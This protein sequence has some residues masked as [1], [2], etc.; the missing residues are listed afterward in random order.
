MSCE[1]CG[2]SLEDKRAIAKYCS[3]A[4]RAKGRRQKVTQTS[5]RPDHGHDWTWERTGD[6]YRWRCGHCGD[7]VEARAPT[8][9]FVTDCTSAKEAV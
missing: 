9:R 7:T 1:T 8:E 4:C 5:A 6:S 3:D 2:T